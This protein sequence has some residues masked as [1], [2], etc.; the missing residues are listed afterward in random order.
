M[1]VMTGVRGIA[2]RIG[3]RVPW[4]RYAWQAVRQVPEA[5]RLAMDS[6]HSRTYY[7]HEARKSRPRIVAENVFWV[8]RHGEPCHHY[9]AY[10][11]DRKGA[12]LTSVLSYAEFRR[13]RDAWN[14]QVSLS[15]GYDY[16]CLL[17]DKFIFGQLAQSLGIPSPRNLAILSRDAVRWLSSRK[18]G[19]LETLLELDMEGFCK[20]QAGIEGIGAFSLRVAGGH[21]FIDRIAATLDD[22]ASRLEGRFLLQER[23]VQHPDLSVLHPSSINTLR[24]VTVQSDDGAHVFLTFMRVGVAGH[25]VDNFSA[26]GMLIPVDPATGTLRGPGL[27]RA[28]RLEWV[29]EHADTGL[30]FDGYPLPFYHDALALARSFHDHLP[31]IHSIGWDIAFTPDGPMIIEGNDNWGAKNVMVLEPDFGRRFLALLG[32]RTAPS[33]R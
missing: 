5:V 23:V 8:V 6:V 11:L 14:R 20:P 17:R 13:I 30:V 28:E 21:L 16:L 27:R 9:F 26:G 22:L 18:G 24:A 31:Y 29:A 25:E 15:E 3:W 2:R 4:V 12:R 10:G 7:P 19:P 32:E 1:R 33:A